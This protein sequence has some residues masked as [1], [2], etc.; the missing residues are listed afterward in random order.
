[1]CVPSLN[2]IHESVFELSHS[3]LKVFGSG[4]MEV[5]PVY[6]RLLTRPGQNVFVYISIRIHFL[7]VFV[8]EYFCEKC[9]VFVFEYISKVFVFMNTF[10]NTF[11]IFQFLLIFFPLVLTSF[12]YKYEIWL[13]IIMCLRKLTRHI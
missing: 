6:P 1:M 5:K 7:K 8:F 4:M 10:M 2:E 11:N 3:Q 12:R 9:K 13:S